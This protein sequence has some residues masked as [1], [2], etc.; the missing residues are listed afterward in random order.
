MVGGSATR[1]VELERYLRTKVERM[2]HL[3]D[4]PPDAQTKQGE[5]HERNSSHMQSVA[6]ASGDDE[7]NAGEA[8]D[9]DAT[10]DA[11]GTDPDSL[12]DEN[13]LRRLAGDAE[14]SEAH[15]DVHHA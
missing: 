6:T 13:E 5:Q 12:L 4:L 7:A 14:H 3:L 1:S 9:D 10:G 15:S 8:D 2:G 11:T